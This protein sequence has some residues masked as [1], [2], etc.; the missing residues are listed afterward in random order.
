[1]IAEAASAVG[2]VEHVVR[3]TR[4]ALAVASDWTACAD[5]SCAS[6]LTARRGGYSWAVD[7]SAHMEFVH[8]IG[9]MLAVPAAAVVLLASWRS[10]AEQRR[11]RS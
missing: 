4:C 1:M 11:K 7:H 10:F 2:D 8:W 3:A 6:R 5:A 9:V